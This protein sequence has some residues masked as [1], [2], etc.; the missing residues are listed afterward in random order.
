MR[1]NR[2]SM[3][4]LA[5]AAGIAVAGCGG[6]SGSLP[7]DEPPTPP[8]PAVVD[9]TSFVTDQFAATADD[10]DP[11]PVDETDFE[12]KDQDNPDAFAGLLSDP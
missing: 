11:E 3:A 8:P 7:P 9:F 5:L 2:L 12:F 1:K 6:G 4:M 10:T